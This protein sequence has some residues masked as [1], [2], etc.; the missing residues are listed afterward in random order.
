MKPSARLTWVRMYEQTRDVG[1]T[2]LCCGVSRATLRKW[3]R[4]HQEDGMAGFMDCSR[5][6]HR[7]RH[8]GRVETM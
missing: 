3:W 2:C 6:P 1:L 5:R 8:L 4:R 7:W